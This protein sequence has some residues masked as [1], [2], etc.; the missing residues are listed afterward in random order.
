MLEAR[1]AWE[2]YTQSWKTPLA[3]DK[4]ALLEQAVVSECVYTDPLSQRTGWDDLIAYMLEFHAQTP[5]G[6]FH[7]VEFLTHNQR[8]IARW[9]MRDGSERV[10]GHGMSYAEYDVEG[11]LT[12][13][14]GFFSP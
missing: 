9:E 10:L 13:M 14:T 8:S 4:R 11:K 12:A 1:E 2:T 5:G 3:A 7:T 6:Y